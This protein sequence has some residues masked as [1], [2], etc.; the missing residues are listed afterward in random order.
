MTTEVQ[1][2]IKMEPSLRDPFMAAAAE[3]HRPAAQIIRGL[4]RLYL[5]CGG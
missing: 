2:P 5:L 3:R 1:M 4:M